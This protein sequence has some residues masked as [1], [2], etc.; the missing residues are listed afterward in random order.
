MTIFSR[1]FNILIQYITNIF[2]VQIEYKLIV[3]NSVQY[4]MRARKIF[5]ILYICQEK[6]ISR[7][8]ECVLLFVDVFSCTELLLAMYELICYDQET[9]IWQSFL[10]DNKIFENISIAFSGIHSFFKLKA[11]NWDQSE[12]IT[13]IIRQKVR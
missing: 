13:N 3:D 11:M 10:D 1:I 6:I 8:L 2:Q 5:V 12:V 9:L 4:L 7:C